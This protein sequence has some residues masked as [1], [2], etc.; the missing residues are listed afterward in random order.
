MDGPPPPLTPEQLALLPHDDRGP[1]LVASAWTMT[2]FASTFLA[3]RVWCKV[4]LGGRG[5]WW[6][7]WILIA[8]W[9]VLVIDAA[10]ATHMVDFYGY[11][12]HSWDFMPPSIDDFF[13]NTLVRA[14]FTITAIAW[15]K[16][17]F[18]VTLLRLTE[19]WVKQVLWFIVITVNLFLG[20]SAF[21]PWIKCT[22]PVEKSWKVTMTTGGDCWLDFDA[23]GKI[24]IF[25]GAWSAAADFALAI[26][27]WTLL[28]GLQMK[29]QEKIGVG[30]AMSMGILAGIAAVVK[31]AKLPLLASGDLYDGVELVIWDMTEIVVC[32]V[33]ACIPVLR[34]LVREV[35]NTT[36]GRSS[37]GRAT[38]YGTARY[39]LGSQAGTNGPSWM[40]GWKGSSR[41]AGTVASVTASRLDNH[42]HRGGQMTSRSSRDS[43]GGEGGG[44]GDDWSEMNIIVSTAPKGESNG[45]VATLAGP[46]DI[47]RIQEVRVESIRESLDSRGL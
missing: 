37:S 33:A 38:G 17:A 1:A 7:D 21:L 25:S 19:G 31:T 28:V 42:K 15:T 34:V 18:A 16:T 45:H 20:L 44:A 5:L 26:L 23:I 27:P 11:G 22:D 12:K 39:G 10:L 9:V 8:S 46:G 43:S 41:N 35:R 13:L 30:I 47:V 14:T 6:D 3:L 36:R 40:P 32:M 4:W 24:S 29:L 2:V